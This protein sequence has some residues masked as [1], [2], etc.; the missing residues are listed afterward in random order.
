MPQ[1]SYDKGERRFK[2]VGS[3]DEPEFQFDDGNPKKVVGKCPATIP[4][5]ERDRLLQ[6]AVPLDN[7]DRD[8]KFPKKLYAVYQGAIYEAQTS[9]FG[10]TYHAYPFRGKLSGAVLELL[11]AMADEEKCRGQFEI[12]RKQH[13]TRHGR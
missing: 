3:G 5:A 1:R 12:W 10:K 13:I 6:K 9:D 2:H 4:D 7:G 8:I 11:E